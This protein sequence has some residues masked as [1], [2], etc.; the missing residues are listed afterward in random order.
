MAVLDQLVDYHLRQGSYANGIPYA[1][2]LLQIDSLREKTY[3]Q[4]MEL[5]ARSGEREAA[6]AQ[7]EACRLNW[8]KTFALRQPRNCQHFMNV[9]RPG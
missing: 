4:L 2:R 9:S 3:G 1:L 6:L 5:L 7:F 8:M